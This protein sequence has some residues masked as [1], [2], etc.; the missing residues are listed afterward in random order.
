[1]QNQEGFLIRQQLI[2]GL[3]VG[4][5]EQCVNFIENYLISLIEAKIEHSFEFLICTYPDNE[6]ETL[7][8]PCKCSL[9]FF[10]GFSLGNLWQ[11]Y[12]CGFDISHD[13]KIFIG[14]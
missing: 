9:D 3:S 2:S 12:V 8:V 7:F 13:G 4:E 6:E 1:M 11:M 10:Y 14:F 5:E